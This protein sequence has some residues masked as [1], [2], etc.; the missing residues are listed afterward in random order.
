MAEEKKQKGLGNLYK[1]SS[2]AMTRREWR[3]FK[4]TFYDFGRW[5]KAYGFMAIK[6]GGHPILLVKAM[7]RY[8]WMISYLTAANM[9]DRHTI[10]Y[11]GKELRYIHEELYSLV[12]NATLNVRKIL[13]MDKNLRPKSKKAA[14]LRAN[15][16]MFDEMSPKNLMWGFPT[17]DWMDIAMMTI[18]MPGEVDQ[19]ANVYYIDRIEEFGM[20]ADVCPLPAAECGCAVSDDFPILVAL[21]TLS[22]AGVGE[23]NMVPITDRR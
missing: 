3:G 1:A 4:D 20:A 11:R 13:L 16:L 5:L 21:L 22:Q 12:R 18:G 10:G 14:K 19:Q 6:L 15:C 9:I 17:L 8:R 7:L 2:R 23:P